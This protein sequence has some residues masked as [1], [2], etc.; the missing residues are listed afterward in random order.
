MKIPGTGHFLHFKIFCS[1]NANF[2]MYPGIYIIIVSRL[3]DT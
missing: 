2:D 3:E 1:I